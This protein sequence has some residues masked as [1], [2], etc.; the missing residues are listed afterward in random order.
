MGQK[1]NPIGLRLGV[2]RTWDSTWYAN[3]NQ[4]AALVKEDKL[5]RK[6]LI[7]KYKDGAL[8]RVEIDRNVNQKGEPCVILKLFTAKPGMVLGRDGAL[9]KEAIKELTKIVKKEVQLSI[10]DVKLAE[11]NA[12]IIADTMARKL[13]ARASFR[14]VQK[15]A[16]QRALKQGA[17]GI[18]TVVSGRLGGAEIARAEGYNEGQVP[19]H[20]L[21]AD[22]DYA[23]AEALTKYGI[24]GIK[25]WV[26]QGEV[27]PG[28]SRL[29]NLRKEEEK[30]A[31]QGQR[32]GSRRT[33]ERPTRPN[34]D[35]RRANDN[36]KPS[37]QD[38]KQETEKVKGGASNVKSKEN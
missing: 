15:F 6:Y 2:I 32:K 34:Q 36:K 23:T 27:L 14:R 37:N 21:R 29:E 8:A 33:G 7:K 38:K 24:L 20:T 26:N 3:H 1:V 28:Q 31:G 17:K 35:R 12:Q 9:K 16:I 30:F 25:V 13:E 4:V 11:R 22:I 5:I 10:F 18:K 19:L